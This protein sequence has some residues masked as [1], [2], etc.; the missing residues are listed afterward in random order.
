MALYG[1]YHRMTTYI[2][3]HIAEQVEAA[4][5]DLG[6]IWRNGAFAGEFG[7]AF[8]Q[9]TELEGGHTAPAIR[10]LSAIVNRV[11]TARRADLT[12]LSDADISIAKR[13]IG[14]LDAAAD[15]DADKDTVSDGPGFVA[16]LGRFM[17]KLKALKV[18]E[19]MAYGGGWMKKSGGHGMI[20]P[21]TT[22][23]VRTSVCLFSDIRSCVCGDVLCDVM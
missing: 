11:L 13:C 5:D 15:L 12:L 7:D 18:G 22:L 10:T 20:T 14:D 23:S 17:T 9:D 4:K 21:H 16:F 3:P 8:I 2:G 19:R 6:M 1:V